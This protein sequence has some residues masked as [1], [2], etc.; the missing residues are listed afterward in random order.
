MA[1][2]DAEGAALAAPLAA[3]DAEAGATGGGSAGA[4]D[5]VAAAGVDEGLAD[6]DGLV[7][8][9]PPV[10]PAGCSSPQAA[11][12]MGAT[13]TDRTRTSFRMARMEAPT[14]PD[15]KAL[16]QRDE[17]LLLWADRAGRAFPLTTNPHS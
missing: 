2:A 15:V 17:N 7:V 4:A 10:V 14:S 6:A 8:A 5:D 9:A 3:A 13:R 16:P 1:A 12:S 11:M